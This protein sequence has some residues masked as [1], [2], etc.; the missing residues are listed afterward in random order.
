MSYLLTQ[1]QRFIRTTDRKRQLLRPNQ[2][3][4]KQ[5]FS[6]D[7]LLKQSEAELLEPP[8]RSIAVGSCALEENPFSHFLDGIQRSWLL[9]YVESVPVYYGYT[10]AV[11]RQRSD[12]V[13]STWRYQNKEAIYLPFNLCSE[14]QLMGDMTLVDTLSK[15]GEIPFDLTKIARDKI[16]SDRQQLEVHLAESWVR[17]SFSGWLVVD[18]SITISPVLANTDRVV[19]LIKSHNTQYFNHT[20]QQI[21]VN[22]KQG[23]RTSTFSP[24]SRHPICSWYLRIREGIG[25]DLHFG[26]VRVEVALSQQHQADE[27]SRWILTETRPL[28]LP[29]SR[30]DRM[31]YP[32]RDCEMYLRSLEPHRSAFGWLY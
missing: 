28:A 20:D 23:E 4:E 16:T 12:R 24:N 30:W 1:L 31:I 17:Q 32:I 19:G 7:D 25:E 15:D 13:L 11:I 2:Y 3:E 21:V 6:G 10:A 8:F 22:L 29:D 26:L 14:S 27:I 9:Y 18:G 5:G